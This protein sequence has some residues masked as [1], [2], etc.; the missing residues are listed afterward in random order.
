[1]TVTSTPRH[2]RS[3]ARHSPTGP[4]PTIQTD[5]DARIP[6]V[7]W[8]SVTLGGNGVGDLGDGLDR[9]IEEGGTQSA[10]RIQQEDLRVVFDLIVAG[11]LHRTL[12]ERSGELRGDVVNG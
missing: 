6:R 7:Y 2:A 4:P 12:E 9:S 1:M 8:V 10:L 11:R 3:M 5:V